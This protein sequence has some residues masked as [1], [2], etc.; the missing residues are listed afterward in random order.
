MPDASAMPFLEVANLAVRFP[1]RSGAWGRPASVHAVN[2]VSLS[3]FAG[4]AVGLVGESGCGKTTLGR[5]SLRL[6]EASAGTVSFAGTDVTSLSQRQLRP[7]RSRFQMVF[8]D[9]FGSL[10]P[11][12]TVG[13]S[14]AEPLELQGQ[15]R[16]QV[17]ER[18]AELVERVGLPAS[19]RDR[20]PHEFS[21]GQ[22]QRIGIARALALD[23]ALL[24]CDEPVSALDV[25]VQAQ[26]VN[27][28]AE[29]QE[30]R[31]LAYLFI[32]HDLA[33]VEHL[34]R[35][36]LVMYLGRVVEAG[37]TAALAR[38]PRHPYTR[39]LWSAVPT[40]DPSGRT[41]VMLHGDPPSPLNPPAGCPFH[42]RCPVAEAR[43]RSERPELR[44]I[45]PGWRV[46]CHLADG[47]AVESSAGL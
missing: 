16:E 4:E 32:S 34:C 37:P 2:G 36:T 24:V 22:R 21:G 6:V 29:L 43:C 38:D 20:F 1:V 5:A 11:R 44:D 3:V 28:F 8:Q 17:R 14:V 39:A 19:C 40:L 25:S 18:V 47:G 46:A 30:T 27:L 35:R 26:I 7:F 13:Q 15:A 9:P 33:V 41:R 45:G 42:P 12:R 31:G 23:P 10:N